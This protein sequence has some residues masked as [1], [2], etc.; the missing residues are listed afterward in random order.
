MSS[1]V[2]VAV[3]CLLVVAGL[4]LLREVMGERERDRL[5][6]LSAHYESELSRQHARASRELIEEMDTQ[7]EVVG[8][9][10]DRLLT[11]IEPPSDATSD[12]PPTVLEAARRVARDLP[13]EVTGQWGD[14]Q[15]LDPFPL[16]QPGDRPSAM[17]METARLIEPV[18]ATDSFLDFA[19][20]PTNLDAYQETV[21]ASFL[22]DVEEPQPLAPEV[23]DINPSRAVTAT[24]A[25]LEGEFW[26]S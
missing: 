26:Q 23:T 20:M 19:D 13:P 6:E 11:I 16:N 17:L 12:L 5:V 4:Y 2:V 8:K 22:G 3:V 21:D 18:P 7:R 9:L 15:A 1:D 14:E 24:P 25:E 10:I